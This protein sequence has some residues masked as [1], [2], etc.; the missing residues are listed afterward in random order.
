MH[1]IL[2]IF[3]YLADTNTI[4]FIIM[5]AILYAIIR[6]LNVGDILEDLITK[7]QNTIKQSETEKE[8]ARI[9]QLKAKASLEKLPEEIKEI[10]KFAKQKSEIFEEKLNESCKKTVDRINHNTN[11]ILSIEEKKISNEIEHQA[12]SESINSAR[13]NIISLLEENPDMHYEFIEESI[14][15]FERLEI[16]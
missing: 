16:K 12:V 13:D 4:N 1:N 9:S 14:K 3:K 11:K 15:E 5:V 6:K 8:N 2:T 7:T 10:K